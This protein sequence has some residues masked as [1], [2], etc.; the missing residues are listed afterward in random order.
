MNI[1]SLNNQFSIK[2][3]VVFIEKPSGQI[4]VKINN[5]HAEAEIILQGAH[6]I[7][8]QPVNEEPVIWLSKDAVFE[9]SKS[10]RG[11]I[12]ICWPWFGAH[13]DGS[14]PA[15]GYARTALWQPV[16]IKQLSDG[17][18]QLDFLLTESSVSEEYSPYNSELKIQFIIG[19]DLEI[20][21]VTKNTGKEKLTITEA[22]HTY[23]NVNDIKNISISGLDGCTYLDKPDGFLAKKQDDTIHINSEV[24]R[25]Y[26]DTSSDVIIRD[27]ELNRCILIKKDN[28]ESTV[29]WNPWKE[30][31]CKMGDLGDEGY[32]YMVCVE[33][34]NAENNICIINAGES[35]CLKVLYSIEDIDYSIGD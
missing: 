21:L 8:W 29:V 27:P 16:H 15:H 2:G 19:T 34:A 23:F 28:S 11:G 30:V 3:S 12:P 22:L 33:S 35:H 17:R 31:T 24:D 4:S 25:V 13:K 5:R 20:D 9:K 1:G 7:H 26:I 6:L 18:T 10:I 14:L 32:R